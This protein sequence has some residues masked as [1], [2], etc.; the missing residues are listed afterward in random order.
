MDLDFDDGD[1]S[2]HTSH[3]NDQLGRLQ[4][5]SRDLYQGQAQGQLSTSIP[6]HS[7]TLSA[8]SNPTDQLNHTQTLAAPQLQG[9]LQG[10]PD[11]NLSA[12]TLTPPQINVSATSLGDLGLNLDLDSTNGYF[13]ASG[14]ASLQPSAFSPSSLPTIAPDMAYNSVGQL[15]ASADLGQSGV[16]NTANS[17]SPEPGK[18]GA[19]Q[20]QAQ[21]REGR[22][23][24]RGYQ[25]CQSCRDRKVKC[26]LGSEL[27]NSRSHMHY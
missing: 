4:D 18:L 8:L 17:L 24:R 14:Y 22:P 7:R 15:P 20:A 25:A 3:L 2:N 9:G 1:P 13:G 23:H 6:N 27:H 16:Y 10:Y 5:T 26:D 21:A 12:R 19:A 11:P